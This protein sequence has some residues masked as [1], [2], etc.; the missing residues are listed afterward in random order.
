M[1]QFFIGIDISKAT[2]DVADSQGNFL[3][4]F[5][6][7]P[8]GLTQLSACLVQQAPAL[9]VMEATGGLEKPVLVELLKAGLVVALVNPK[10]VRE[11]AKASG[12]LAKT[13]RLDALIIARFAQAI[14]PKPTLLPP[15]EQ[16]QLGELLTRRQQLLKMLV[17]EGNRAETTSPVLLESLHRMQ[18]ALQDE[19]VRIEAA[20]EALVASQPEWQAE[21]HNLESCKGVGTITALTLKG[22]LPELG[23]LDHK[24][25]AALVGLAPM[26][27]DSGSRRGKR[28]VTGGRSEVRSVLYMATISASRHNPQ[29]RSF[30]HS[31]LDRGKPKKLALTAC[32]RKLLSILNA[33]ARDNSPWICPVALDA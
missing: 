32:M 27:H 7:T 21:L 33:M 16:Q 20:I 6:R 2:C 28:F 5:R 9:I 22:H 11:F 12:Q 14:R 26:N 13:D 15:V 17:S 10:R 29:I 31:L 8:D 23:K 3:G 30:Y 1:S 18:A 24:Q 4:T 25:V 19:L